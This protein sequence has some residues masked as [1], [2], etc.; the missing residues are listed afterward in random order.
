M[1]GI[2]FVV[3][4]IIIG[5][6]GRVFISVPLLVFTSYTTLIYERLIVVLCVKSF[7]YV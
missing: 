4:I 7:C 5:E 2:F 3:I 1:Q 6:R